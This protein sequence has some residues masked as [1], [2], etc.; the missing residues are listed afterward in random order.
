M[1]ARDASQ[2]SRL[3]QIPN[4]GPAMVRDLQV[5]GITRPAQLAG[6]DAYRLYRQLC[7]RTGVRHDPCVLDTLIS[8]VRFMEGAPPRPWWHYTADRKQ[9]YPGI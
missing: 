4:I 2:A 8:A 9:R 5:L 7:Q 3:R 1:K 6:K